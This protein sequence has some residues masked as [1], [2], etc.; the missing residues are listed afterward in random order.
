MV[1]TR[2][3][4]ALLVAFSLVQASSFAASL[5]SWVAPSETSERLASHE[6]DQVLDRLLEVDWGLEL[7]FRD[8]LAPVELE[9]RPEAME[10][11]QEFSQGDFFSPE[12]GRVRVVFRVRSLPESESQVETEW[13]EVTRVVDLSETTQAPEPLL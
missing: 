7:G 2:S 5:G 6:R 8:P 9:L 12:S 1:S 10:R 4:F 13:V 3:L 11:V